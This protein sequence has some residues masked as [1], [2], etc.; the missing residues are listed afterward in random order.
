MEL[1]W[2]G[3]WESLPLGRVD[4]HPR[5]QVQQMSNGQSICIALRAL[6]KW[7]LYF[8]SIFCFFFFLYKNVEKNK[9]QSQDRITHKM[10]GIQ[11]LHL[12]GQLAYRI[13]A[14]F[15]IQHIC[16][17]IFLQKKYARSV[18]LFTKVRV[19]TTYPEDPCA[20][21]PMWATKNQWQAHPVCLR[22][23]LSFRRH[24]R[25]TLINTFKECINQQSHVS[26]HAPLFNCAC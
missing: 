25:N 21:E 22:Y 2:L 17:R 13:P 7:K 26:W 10:D 4:F 9:T 11:G 12:A 19:W 24:R 5:C 3:C 15:N 20:N 1:P 18:V 6:F 16:Q 23:I 8:L 14:R